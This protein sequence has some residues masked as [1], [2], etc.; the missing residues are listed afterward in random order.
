MQTNSLV[1]ASKQ[2]LDKL[3]WF[4]FPVEPDWKG[5]VYF[6]ILAGEGIKLHLTAQRRCKHLLVY[7]TG[8]SQVLES[9]C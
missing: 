6:V 5:S 7:I 9:K 8:R 3:L 1:A 2:L 4:S